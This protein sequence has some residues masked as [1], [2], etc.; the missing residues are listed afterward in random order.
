MGFEE[1]ILPRGDSTVI[2]AIRMR[3]NSSQDNHDG[4]WDGKKKT[5]L[6]H[7]LDGL[8]VG[9]EGKRRKRDTS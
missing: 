5:D 8:E 2:V 9:Q 7:V 6:K 4:G 1:E 3:G